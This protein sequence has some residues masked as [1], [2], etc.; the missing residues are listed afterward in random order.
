MRILKEMDDIE[1]YDL[2]KGDGKE[3]KTHE[4]KTVERGRVEVCIIWTRK[5]NAD[6]VA[7]T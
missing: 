2:V 3:R 7:I 5:N 1:A 4:A 6:V